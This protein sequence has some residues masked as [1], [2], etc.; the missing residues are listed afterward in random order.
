M[1]VISSVPVPL[2]V[3]VRSPPTLVFVRTSPKDNPGSTVMA[4]ATPVPDRATEVGVA[5]GFSSVVKLSVAVAAPPASGMNVTVK[6][7]VCPTA[8]VCSV[9]GETVKELWWVPPRAG[10]T[11]T[12]AFPT[13]FTVTVRA[14]PWPPTTASPKVCEDG[15][16]WAADNTP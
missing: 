12:A 16:T 9:L 14:T 3:T 15:L 4:G 2:L 6:E 5:T 7:A 13:F 8:M 10:V 1:S 11:L